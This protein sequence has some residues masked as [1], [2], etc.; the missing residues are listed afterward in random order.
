MQQLVGNLRSAQ[1]IGL[2]LQ[3]I[4]EQVNLR[5]IAPLA[6]GFL[7]GIEAQSP[8]ACRGCISGQDVKRR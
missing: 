5:R 7:P 4:G 3:F 2:H 6:A 1:S 8:A